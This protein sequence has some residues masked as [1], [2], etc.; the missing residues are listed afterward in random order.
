M[1]SRKPRTAAGRRFVER[2]GTGKQVEIVGIEDEA[3]A[4]TQADKDT[5]YEWGREDATR[6][7]SEQVA[8]LR[9]A[10]N[11]ALN[12]WRA[13]AD[14]TR[15]PFGP[16]EHGHDDEADLFASSRGAFAATDPAPSPVREP[17]DVKEMARAIHATNIARCREENCNNEFG[18][19][20]GADHDLANLLIREYARRVSQ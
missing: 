7:A 15:G 20:S 1:D 8:A 4:S 9:E 16:I 18:G 3:I 19:F 12:Q 11:T 6:A 2:H 5:A 13:Y 10:L 17:L 14:R